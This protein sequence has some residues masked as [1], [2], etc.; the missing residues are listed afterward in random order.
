MVVTG[1]RRHKVFGRVFQTEFRIVIAAGDDFAVDDLDFGV[2][3]EADGPL[4]EDDGRWFELFLV[5]LGGGF[6]LGGGFSGFVN[7]LDR[8]ERTVE[9]G[10]GA[11]VVFFEEMIV[12]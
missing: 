9:G 10:F 2:L 4:I 1:V 8:G 12:V 5:C 3:I 6:G 11:G 7:G